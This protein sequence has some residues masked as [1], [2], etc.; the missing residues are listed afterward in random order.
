[1]VFSLRDWIGLRVALQA[2]C[3]SMLY[4]LMTG[5][6]RAQEKNIHS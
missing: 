3:Q 1:M 5:Q 6:V 4:Q 2:L